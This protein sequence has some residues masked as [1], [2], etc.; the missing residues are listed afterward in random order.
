MIIKLKQKS[1]IKKKNKN[2]FSKFLYIYFFLTF[3]IGILFVVMIFQSHLFNLKK[4]KILD[5][6]SKA[7][8]YEYLY[9]PN[10]IFKGI[11]SNFTS[12][13]KIQIEIPFEETIILENLR[14]KSILDGHLPPS[15]TMPRV[16]AK[17]IFNNNKLKTDIRLKGD[18]LVHF[19][20]KKNSSYRFELGDDE[21]ILGV[22]KFSLQKP[23]VR[24]Y[25]HEWLF[26]ELSGDNDIIKLIYEFIYLEI[27]GEDQGLYVLEEAFGK[28]LIERNKRRNG[29]IFGLNEDIYELQDTP[30]FE[31]YNKNFWAKSEN[32][33]LAR[34]ASQKLKDFW[35]DKLN[36]E[37]VFDL[38]K[39][40]TYFAIID[41]TGTFHGSLPKSVKL[42]YNPATAKFEPIGYDGH[43]NPNIFNN[44][45]ILDFL[46]IDNNNCDYICSDREWFLRFL[47]NDKFLNLYLNKLEEISTTESIKEFYEI[48]LN[49]I[50]FSN[51]QFNSEPSKI[52]KVFYKGLGFYQFD[53][54][55]LITRSDYIKNRIKKYNKKNFL[56]IK[57]KNILDK[58][59]TNEAN[60][61]FDEG[62]YFLKNNLEISQR[63]FL[64]KEK[65]LIIEK[66]VEIKFTKDVSIISE[67]SIYMNGTKEK[68]I[69]IYSD[70]KIGSLILT[71]NLFKINNVIFKNLSYP[72]DSNK[73]LYGGINVINSDLE[74]SNT[75]ILSSNSE[76]AINI[77][78]S[79]SSI[80]NLDLR[81]IYSDAIDIDFGNLIFEKI[82][83]EVINNDCLD[84][85][86]AKIDGN[87][88]S[89]KYIKDKGLSFGE[90]S[91]GKI[92][93]VDFENTRLGIAVKDGSSLK[94]SYYTFLNNEYDVMV[95]NKKKEYPN[96]SL[97]LNNPADDRNLNYLIGNNNE[98]IKEGI[99]LTKKVN[100]KYINNLLY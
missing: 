30:V 20:D 55:Y 27:N 75:K 91:T 48:N 41:L 44:F 90:N 74:I 76:D 60:I 80:N 73:I 96:A 38:E 21:Y 79:N 56:N 81:N 28:E 37:D 6:F 69:I 98:I 71:D 15:D 67:G 7:G 83:C 97:H 82:D 10:I 4:N 66:G 33:A 8:R 68:P 40:A 46:D 95:F 14:K 11:K 1:K 70:N 89:G 77:I 47:K 78:S 26:H 32:N 57:S 100:N 49:M 63:Y 34:A 24:N 3:L 16:K 61:V 93:N 2:L 51:E 64:P 62:K 23:R 59:I 53:K 87:Y 50:K 94:I 99:P 18:R 31:I 72:K 92:N 86:G 35:D 17:I 12:L 65:T 85:S 13:K 42:F 43:Y 36:L 9:L 52:D 5:I 22:K 25:I 39:W 45:L 54:N 88:I 58:D 84:V 19:E 29:P